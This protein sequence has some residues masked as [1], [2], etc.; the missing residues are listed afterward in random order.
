M[1]TFAYVMKIGFVSEVVFEVQIVAL[2]DVMYRC[3]YRG[4][5]KLRALAL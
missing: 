5:R 4:D 3:R 2:V 1:V